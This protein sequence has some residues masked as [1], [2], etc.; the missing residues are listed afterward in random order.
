ML[1]VERFDRAW[2][3]D[4]WLARLPQEDLCQALGVPSVQKYESDG[5]PGIVQCLQV[6]SGSAAP[7][8]DSARFVMAQFAFWLLGAI[9]GHAKNFSIFIQPGGSYVMTPLYDVLSAWPVMGHGHGRIEIQK[10]KMAMAIPGEKS[11]HYHLQ[12]IQRRHWKALAE[13]TRIDGLWAAML[14]MLDRLDAAIVQVQANLHHSVEPK[15]AHKIFAGTQ[16]QAEK[17]RSSP[18][19]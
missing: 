10:A 4:G 3:Q 19:K 7:A 6:L 5:G 1:C 17:F 2:T 13:R 12:K 15:L 14:A 8:I 11:R 16:R 9:D 18:D